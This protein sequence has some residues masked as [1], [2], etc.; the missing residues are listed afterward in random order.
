[1][2][3]RWATTVTREQSGLMDSTILQGRG[4]LKILEQ[5]TKEI[6][7]L[8]SKNIIPFNKCIVYY[9]R[10]FWQPWWQVGWQAIFLGWQLPPRWFRHCA[11]GIVALFPYL[12][13]P[14]SQHG[15]VSI[16]QYC[17][18]TTLCIYSL[19]ELLIAF[20]FGYIYNYIGTLLRSR[21]WFWIPCMAI[22]DH[23]K[24]KFRGKRWLS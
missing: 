1:M 18:I 8:S 9:R 12:E 2:E 10:H 13:D 5:V 23:S 20:P 22:E 24:K 7:S 11:Q 6:N 17:I 21:E 3:R 15:Y 4:N 14:F 16:S 19:F